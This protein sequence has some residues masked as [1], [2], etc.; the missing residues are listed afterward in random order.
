MARLLH[1]KIPNVENGERAHF[2]SCIDMFF[3][4]AKR[5][6]RMN[7]YIIIAQNF[8]NNKKVT[9]V[10]ST[11]IFK[12]YGQNEFIWTRTNDSGSMTA[13]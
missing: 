5:V 12:I 1:D 8:Q 9:L 2:L 13:R 11:N 6:A 3:P 10:M 4:M 7:L